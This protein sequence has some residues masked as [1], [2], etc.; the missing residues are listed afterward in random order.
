MICQ[1]VDKKFEDKPFLI[2]KMV[3]ELIRDTKHAD[4]VKVVKIGEQEDGVA[5]T[6]AEVE[7]DGSH[8]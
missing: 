7:G 8:C 6:K 1:P 4:R 5:E 2:G 3:V